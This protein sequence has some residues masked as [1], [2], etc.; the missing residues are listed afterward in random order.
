MIQSMTGYGR[1]AS[2]AG[3]RQITAEIKAVNHRY[4]EIQI[5]LPRKFA[6]L[7]DRLRQHVSEALDRG[8]I[9]LFIKVE[10][11]EADNKAVRVDFDL[12]RKQYDTI[13]ELSEILGIAMNFGV[14]ELVALPGIITVEEQED[15]PDE[16]WLMLAEP[17]DA[18]IAC[19]LEMRKTE[20][21][22]LTEDFNRRLDYLEELR[23]A[24]LAQ[25]PLVVENYRKRLF[26]R[27]EELMDR[28]P[29]DENRLVQEVA[30]FADRAGVDEE[31]V[32]LDSHIKQFR[33]LLIA[34]DAVGRKLDF[35]C[36]EMFREINTT[37]SKANDLTMTKTI[38]EMKS[39][40]EKLREQVQNIK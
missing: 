29:V 9:D 17:V 11:R 38:V 19:L 24:L 31:L 22:R 5:R 34:D 3:A 14:A 39:E 16:V 1:G 4:C 20:G 15:E 25:S 27:I 10:D 7:E 33:E 35:I 2:G 32:R 6:L 40:L 8:K 23:Q 26:T 36:Q 37:G 21:A 12:A 28:Q 30:M 13:R 18:A